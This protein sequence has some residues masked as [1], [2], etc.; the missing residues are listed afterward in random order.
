MLPTMRRCFA[1]IKSLDVRQVDADRP[2]AFAVI[3]A[4]EKFDLVISN[5]PWEDGVVTLN[6]QITLSMIQ[7]FD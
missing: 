4:G 1:Q 2:S 5:P 7:N 6:L 3:K